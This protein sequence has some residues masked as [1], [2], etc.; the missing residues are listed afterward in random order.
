MKKLLL[1]I[2]GLLLLFSV[3]G[4]ILRYS[5]YTAPTPP[6]PGLSLGDDILDGMGAF[7]SATGWITIHWTISG[8]VAT[9]NMTPF[10]GLATSSLPTSWQTETDYR[11]EFDIVATGGNVELAFT[12]LAG[13]GVD[14]IPEDFYTTGSYSFDFTSP[15]T[16]PEQG[17]EIYNLD[18]STASSVTIDNLTIRPIL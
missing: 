14:L 13:S 11:L 4:Q 18:E 3:E 12:Y 6:E 15:A 17:L 7:D 8:G 2:T 9:C 16:I 1:L 5:N 10:S